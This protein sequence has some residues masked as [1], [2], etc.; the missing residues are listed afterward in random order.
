MT[1]TD[2]GFEIAGKFHEHVKMQME[3]FNVQMDLHAKSLTQLEMRIVEYHQKTIATYKCIESADNENV[4]RIEMAEGRAHPRGQLL[5][6]PWHRL[7]GVV[8]R[9]GC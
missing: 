1:W 6:H 9:F 3:R 7:V 2:A 4:R 8:E 5:N